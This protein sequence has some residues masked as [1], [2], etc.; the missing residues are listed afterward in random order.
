[1]C[2]PPPVSSNFA[3]ISSNDLY[4]PIPNTESVDEVVEEPSRDVPNTSS[5]YSKDE[6]RPPKWFLKTLDVAASNAW[7][8]PRKKKRANFSLMEK[9]M[10]TTCDPQSY[11]KARDKPERQDAIAEEYNFD[12]RSNLGVGSS[13]H[14]EEHC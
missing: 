12:E 3:I 5:S 6:I 2:S 9:F 4:V 11:K 7:I 13:S 10:A 1:L 14:K 8:R